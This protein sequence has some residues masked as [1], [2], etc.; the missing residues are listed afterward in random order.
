MLSGTAVQAESVRE[1][2]KKIKTHK[3]NLEQIDEQ[4]KSLE[5]ED[6]RLK[7]DADF[8]EKTIKKI[9]ND[10]DKSNKKQ[11]AQRRRISETESQIR[12]MKQQISLLT[13][14]GRMWENT[15]FTD[16]KS[17]HQEIAYP[18]RMVHRPMEAWILRAAV[19][20]RVEQMKD[21]HSKI[22][23]SQDKERQLAQSKENLVKMKSELEGEIARQKKIKEEKARLHKTTLG[24]RLI[25]QGEV[26]RLNET[27]DALEKLIGNL[28]AKK[29]K[30]LTEQREAELAKKSFHERRGNLPWPVEGTVTVPFGH[31]KHPDL[32]I[33]VIHNGIKIKTQQGVPVKAVEKG[34]VIYASDFRSYGQ[35]VILDH[36]GN[37]FSVY[38]L[39]GDI[40]V[41]EG[42]KV[43]AGRGIGTTGEDEP[44]QIYFEL[45]NQGRSEDPLLWLSKR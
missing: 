25:A 9:E 29:E 23:F 15:I 44:S 16:L 18:Q 6:T 24:K 7:K 27:R 40:S 14:E 35:T 13:D 36:G 30:T 37:T 3:K 32:N 21:T 2:N 8:L 1:L 5:D 45:K 33:M 22:V 39:L 31:R 34:T 12:Q 19:A 10:I 42:E 28:A 4:I 11:V 20:L 41:K 26:Q 38:G 17:Y 43:T